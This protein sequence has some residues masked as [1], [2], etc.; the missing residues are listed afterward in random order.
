MSG[1]TERDRSG[2]YLCLWERWVAGILKSDVISLKERIILWEKAPDLR[3]P[4]EN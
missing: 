2:D 1:L 3:F 4:Q